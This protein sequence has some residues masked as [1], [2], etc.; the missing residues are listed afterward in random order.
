MKKLLF[1]STLMVTLLGCQSESVNPLLAPATNEYGIVAMDQVRLEH[2]MP[3]FKEAI[4]QNEAEI[5]AI[6]SNPDEPTFENTIVA[7][8]RSG[9]LLERVEGIFFNILEADG[10]DEMDEIANEVSPLLSEL[11]DNI[12]LNETLFARIKVVYD[13]RETLYNRKD[14]RN[15]E[16]YVLM[17]RIENFLI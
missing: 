1:L 4:R 8:E 5:E 6:V 9:S 11:S 7:L 13:Q 3:A 14:V 12:I 17:N 16:G 15:L 2:Y 10:N